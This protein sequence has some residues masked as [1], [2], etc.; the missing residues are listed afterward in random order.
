MASYCT[1]RS[2][3]KRDAERRRRET[4]QVALVPGT[5]AVAVD[6]AAVVDED[7]AEEVD[8]VADE[9]T[10]MLL[11]VS[12]PTPA[13]TATRKATGHVSV[14]NR[15]VRMQSTAVA[16]ET[17]LV[18]AVAIVVEVAAVAIVVEVA[19]AEIRLDSVAGTKEGMR[20]ASST[21]NVKKMVLCFWHMALS[22]WNRARRRTAKRRSTSS[23]LS[24]VPVPTL[25]WM[26]IWT[27]VG[28]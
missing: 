24:H 11:A 28:T 7:E 12:A 21:P 19:A 18:A 27:A 26:K 1:L 8:V 25:A 4:M 3:G 22:A 14:R 15:A 16:V 23:S 10:A 13:S 20:R 2:S 9:E 17:V 6:A 5:S